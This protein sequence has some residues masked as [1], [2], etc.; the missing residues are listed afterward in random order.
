MLG[1]V[2]YLCWDMNGEYLASVSDEIVRVWSVASGECI[3]ELT[4]NE[5]QFYSCVFHPS[6]S[7]L[8]VVGGMRVSDISFSYTLL[9]LNALF[10][11][12]V[13]W[14]GNRM[15]HDMFNLVGV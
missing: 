7:A 9:N 1:I 12:F 8:L 13:G 3:H 11:T 10:S 4:S 6:Y 5:N 15:S 14:K 2:N